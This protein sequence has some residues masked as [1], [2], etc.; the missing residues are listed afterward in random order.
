MTLSKTQDSI[1]ILTILSRLI[2]EYF[3]EL[4]KEHKN[5]SSI[6]YAAVSSQ[7]LI[8]VCSFMDEWNHFLGLSDE[9][10]R[11]IKVKDKARYFAKRINQWSD[12][13]NV[14]NQM[15]VHNLR[16]KT[17]GNKSIL[18]R[19]FHKEINI[20]NKYPDYVV[21]V[22]CIDFITVIIHREFLKEV[23]SLSPQLKQR[24]T[25]TLKSGARTIEEALK[26][27]DEII[28]KSGFSGQT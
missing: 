2:L 24:K 22:G 1:L 8:N 16:D 7:I 13:T 19:P 6:V 17:G 15:L 18:T 25:P 11:I 21:L 5:S 10:D 14:R 23:E 12:L 28:E 27:L 4:E 9:R 3:K 20:P 26:E